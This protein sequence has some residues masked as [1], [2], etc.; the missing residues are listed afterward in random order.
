MLG[1]PPCVG[2][3][4]PTPW[5]RGVRTVTFPAALRGESSNFPRVTWPQ[6]ELGHKCQSLRTPKVRKPQG[7]VQA[8]EPEFWLL[9]YFSHSLVSVCWAKGWAKPQFSSL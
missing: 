7:A 4:E 2:T 9:N 3:A 6:S 5:P 1:W 8:P